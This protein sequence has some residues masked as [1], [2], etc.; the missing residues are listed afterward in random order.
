MR[1][2]DE[3]STV[4]MWR[5]IVAVWVFINPHAAIADAPRPDVCCCYC[6][7]FVLSPVPQYARRMRRLYKARL[8]RRSMAADAPP[9]TRSIL[10]RMLRLIVCVCA[11]AQAL[12]IRSFLSART[13]IR[14]ARTIPSLR[15]R[16]KRRGQPFVAR[17]L[18]TMPVECFTSRLCPK[19]A[20]SE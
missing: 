8:H 19:Q 11:P 10:H 17:V 16:L 3:T 6:R 13:A 9:N 2:S 12:P 18:F 4:V 7:R 5:A 20:A 14:R 1:C 15:A